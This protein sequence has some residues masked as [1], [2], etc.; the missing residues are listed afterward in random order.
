[1][2]KCH[3]VFKTVTLKNKSSDPKKVKSAPGTKNKTRVINTHKRSDAWAVKFE[4]SS[5]SQLLIRIMIHD[6][7]PKATSDSIPSSSK[8]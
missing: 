4:A 5:P 6:L 3:P 1:M 8:G 7:C 2:G